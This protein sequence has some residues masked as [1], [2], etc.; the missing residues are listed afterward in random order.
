MFQDIRK[1]QTL[2][3]DVT[4]TVSKFWEGPG[5]NGLASNVF[6]MYQKCDHSQTRR[7]SCSIRLPRRTNVCWQIAMCFIVHLFFQTDP[8]LFLVVQSR[9]PLTPTPRWRPTPASPAMSLATPL[10]PCP[11]PLTPGPALS[12]TLKQP[13]MHFGYCIHRFESG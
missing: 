10:P 6:Y 12:T 7:K 2:F 8:S 13:I 5:K 9:C 1:F 3:N 11:P 4:P